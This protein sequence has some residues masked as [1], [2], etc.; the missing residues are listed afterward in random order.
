MPTKKLSLY[1]PRVDDDI[2]Y[3]IDELS[4]NM[5]KIDDSYDE[6]V[7]NILSNL[8]VGTQYQRGKKI[9]NQMSEVGGFVG[10]TNIRTGT[11]AP[12]WLASTTY[13]V[14]EKVMPDKNNG[15]YY[16]CVVSGTTTLVEPLFDTMSNAVV[17]DLRGHTVWKPNNH[18]NLNDIIIPTNGDMTYYYRC[19]TDGVSGS[20]EPTWKKVAGDTV[21]DGG[22]VFYVY[23]TVQWRESGESCE[24][25]PFGIV[26][27]KVAKYTETIGDG[28]NDKIVVNHNLGVIDIV[29][30]VRERTG[31]MKSIDVQTEIIDKNNVRVI[32][33][34]PPK[35]DQYRITVI[36]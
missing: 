28:A 27:Q 20:I 4:K 7:P 36:G 16:E 1:Q 2:Q 35:L 30:N 33:S 23:K 10:W 24:F 9:W 26:G 32:F 11:Y 22:A 31:S 14:G 17:F 21:K 6:T 29:V 15:H 13:Q 12:K 34:S 25:V 8:V 5:Q 3:T 18:Y 19:I